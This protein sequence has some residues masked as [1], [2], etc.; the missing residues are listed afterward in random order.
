MMEG[1]VMQIDR[2]G[3]TGLLFL[4]DEDLEL[5]GVDPASIN[6]QEFEQIVDELME[7]YNDN[8]TGVLADIVRQLRGGD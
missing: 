7:Y 5:A 6:D 1:E 4:S 8:F 2:K 3:G